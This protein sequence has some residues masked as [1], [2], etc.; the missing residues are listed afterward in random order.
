MESLTLK[1]PGHTLSMVGAR[2]EAESGSRS[3]WEVH[4]AP[5]DGNGHSSLPGKQPELPKLHAHTGSGTQLPRKLQY[6]PLVCSPKCTST[7][8]F[9]TIDE[10]LAV[11]VI[12]FKEMDHLE[13]TQFSTVCSV[14]RCLTMKYIIPP[15]NPE[16]WKEYHFMKLIP[17]LRGNSPKSTEMD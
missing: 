2:T 7:A 9:R 5:P 15:K 4:G 16:T 17:G 3:P 8:N 12:N 14:H 11:F 10:K 6:K 13:R 1:I